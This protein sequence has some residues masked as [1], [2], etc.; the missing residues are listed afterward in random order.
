MFTGKNDVI[1]SNNTTSVIHDKHNGDPEKV[2]SLLAYMLTILKI[3][4]DTYTLNDVHDT[5]GGTYVLHEQS[6]STVVSQLNMDTKYVIDSILKGIHHKDILPNIMINC[7]TDSRDL[8]TL[9]CK[10]VN[11][12]KKKK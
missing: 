4:K 2:M 1:K 7:D 11:K 6:T 12:H 5:P 8:A 3:Q 10:M 9:C